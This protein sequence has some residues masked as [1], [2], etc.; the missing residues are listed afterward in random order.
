MTPTRVLAIPGSFRRNS[1]NRR[2]LVAAV[3][4]APVGMSISVAEDLASLPIFSED[5]E[6]STP[7]GPE[8]VHRLREQ[9]ELADGL[10]ISTPE[11]N[12]SL[13][14]GLKNVIDWLSRPGP[15]E[16][17]I[18]KPVAIMGASSGRWGTRLA[19]AALRQT[20]TAAEAVVLPQPPLFI[21]EAERLFDDTGRLT[22][23]PTREQ[24][25]NLLSAFARWI[26]RVA[27][28]RAAA[29]RGEP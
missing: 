29:S 22:H 18:G 19:Q 28:E 12:Q 13:P 11:Y 20:L 7:G 9:V 6:Q 15:R 24:L 14:G 1:Y 17:L 16:V 5:L 8:P 10:I 27:P 3:E 2:L 26:D 23:E 25:R 21:R 4:W